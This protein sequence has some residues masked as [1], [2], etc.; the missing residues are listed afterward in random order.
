MFHTGSVAIFSHSAV[1][2]FRQ[3]CSC[4]EYDVQGEEV[5]KCRSA[6]RKA[7]RTWPHHVSHSDGQLPASSSN[8]S[9]AAVVQLFMCSSL[10]SFTQ[11]GGG[12]SC[13]F[14]LAPIPLPT[15]ALCVRACST[16]DRQQM[17][18]EAN[19]PRTFRKA[20]KLLDLHVDCD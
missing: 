14:C 5:Q 6:V 17:C 13:C 12:G 19:D 11:L 2:G 1:R 18:R 16:K 7:G 4:T 3:G 9:A 20:M 15:I 10:V 8:I